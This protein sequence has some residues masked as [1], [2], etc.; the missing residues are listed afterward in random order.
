MQL[1]AKI[2]DSSVK[3][4]AHEARYPISLKCIPSLCVEPP[5]KMHQAVFVFYTQW[6]SVQV[7]FVILLAV[8]SALDWTENGVS[9]FQWERHSPPFWLAFMSTLSSQKMVLWLIDF[10]VFLMD[11][12]EN[13]TND[14]SSSTSRR[15]KKN[16]PD[17]EAMSCFYVN[18]T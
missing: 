9:P 18:S 6:F 2:N 15:K 4:R 16:R 10:N 11:A 17:E 14:K 12:Q 3:F 8:V 1:F 13:R 5:S 7:M